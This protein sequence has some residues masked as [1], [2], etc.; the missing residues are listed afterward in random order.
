[1]VI[2]QHL[3]WAPHIFLVLENGRQSVRLVRASLAVINPLF[4]SLVFLP[5]VVTCEGF[6]AR[7]VRASVEDLI[8][9]VEYL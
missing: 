7:E 2:V 8:L 1:V 6:D 3:H 9:L 4:N 5:G